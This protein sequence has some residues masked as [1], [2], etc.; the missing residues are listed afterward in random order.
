MVMKHQYRQWNEKIE[1][2]DTRPYRHICT[3][4]W[5]KINQYNNVE[6]QQCPEELQVHAFAEQSVWSTEQQLCSFA[7][8]FT[9]TQDYGN[10][11]IVTDGITFI[12]TDRRIVVNHSRATQKAVALLARTH[13]NHCPCSPT[14][15]NL[16][17]RVECRHELCLLMYNIILFTTNF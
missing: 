3:L 4:T 9:H 8:I 10:N 15:G 13:W 2:F 16:R 11:M 12:V 5:L 14:Q 17:Y 6:R 7:P 1:N